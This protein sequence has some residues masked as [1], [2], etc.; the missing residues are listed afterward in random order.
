MVTENLTI[1][2]AG[3]MFGPIIAALVALLADFLGCILVGF[4]I[5][6][7]VMAGAVSI[8]IISGTLYKL[9]SK[10][11]LPLSIRLALTVFSSHIIGS[12]LIKTIG[13]AKWYSL[14]YALS[15]EA[16]LLWRLL[17]YIVVGT[18]EYIILFIL[19]RRRSF[20]KQINSIIE[21]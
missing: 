7:I 10:S 17:N 16:L 1:I 2:L 4:G 21:K 12:V 3:I 9:S 5:N 8:G 19:L 15:F 11:K 18:V 20:N 14:T 6:Y 13:L